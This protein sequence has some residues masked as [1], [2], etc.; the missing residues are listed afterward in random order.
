[1]PQRQVIVYFLAFIYFSGWQNNREKFHLEFLKTNPDCI[2]LLI[3][4]RAK[5]PGSKSRRSLFFKKLLIFGRC[6]SAKWRRWSSTKIS[7]VVH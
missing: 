7:F 2:Y 6:Y 3:D 1:M 5:L 4:Y